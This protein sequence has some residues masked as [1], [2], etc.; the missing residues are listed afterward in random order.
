[1]LILICRWKNEGAMKTMRYIINVLMVL[2]FAGLLFL[3]I[4]VPE[5]SDEV[6]KQTLLVVL[7]MYGAGYFAGRL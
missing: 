3:V 4:T 7:C 6:Y 2:A 5:Y 1:M